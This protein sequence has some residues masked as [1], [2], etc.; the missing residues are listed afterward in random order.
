ML[1]VLDGNLSMT[2]TLCILSPWKN[3]SVAGLWFPKV[4][5][6]RNTGE[7]KTNQAECPQVGTKNDWA[8]GTYRVKSLSC[9][10]I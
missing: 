4:S 7:G 6:C 1:T 9:L 5:T 10:S 2:L 3:A 8:M